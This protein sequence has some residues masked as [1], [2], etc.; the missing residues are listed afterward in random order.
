MA[1]GAGTVKRLRQLTWE[2]EVRLGTIG[3][4]PIV[5]R[6]SFLLGA[7]LLVFYFWTRGTT[8]TTILGFALIGCLVFSVVVHELAHAGAARLFGIGCRR[9]ELNGLGGLAFLDRMPVQVGRRIAILLA[10]PLSNLLL[11]GVFAGL[12]WLT[13]SSP[14]STAALARD[15]NLGLCVFNLLPSFPLDGGRALH[16][17]LVPWFGKRSAELVVGT[18]GLLA[19]GYCFLL[20]IPFPTLLFV[21]LLL[22]QCS[23]AAL[24][25]QWTT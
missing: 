23:V 1:E 11:Y 18:L 5:M 16:A 22:A 2:S 19:A 14:H 9:I 13:R 21:G 4:I 6:L 12:A 20:A 17:L 3:G 7:S 25:G 10:G 24:R 8:R 15:L